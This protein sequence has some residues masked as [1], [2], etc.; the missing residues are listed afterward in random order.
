V[1]ADGALHR[2]LLTPEQLSVAAERVRGI[3]GSRSARRVVTFADRLSESVGESRSRVMMLRAGLPRPR[4]QFQVYDD[5]G[6]WLGRSDYAWNDGRLLGEFDG[7]VKYG[8]LLKPGETAGDVVVKEKLRE[9][10]FRD[11]GARVVRWV[12]ADLAHPADVVH[13]IRRGLLAALV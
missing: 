5:S 7:L 10:A 1:A 3:P 13:R 2:K 9:D 4:L 11:T 6:A 12:W 8:R